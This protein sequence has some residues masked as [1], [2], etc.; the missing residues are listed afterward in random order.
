MSSSSPY[1]DCSPSHRCT[2]TS[3]ARSSATTLGTFRSFSFGSL[4]PTL[5]RLLEAGLIAQEAPK[6][7]IDAVPLTSRRSRVT[8]RLTADGKE[9]L[10]STSWATPDRSRGPTTASGCI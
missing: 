7:D 2:A 10:V 3:C 1:S 6:V 5:R 9:R 8:Y 4:Y